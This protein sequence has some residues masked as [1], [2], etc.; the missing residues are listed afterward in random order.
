M[1]NIATKQPQQPG[2]DLI[3][4]LMGMG[5]LPQVQQ[6]MVVPVQGSPTYPVQAQTPAWSPN[7]F[8]A[9]PTQQAIPMFPNISLDAGLS[10][11]PPQNPPKEKQKGLQGDALNNAMTLANLLTAAGAVFMQPTTQQRNLLFGDLSS[12]FTNQMA[13]LLLTRQ[14]AGGGQGTG[15]GGTG[16]GGTGAGGVNSPFR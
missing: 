8:A 10:S 5:T 2:A 7:P 15:T 9:P 13:N 4:A 3:A 1:P 12:N 6:P 11:G 16:V 14:L